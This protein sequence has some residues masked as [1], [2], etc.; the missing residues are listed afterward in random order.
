MST[1]ATF[2]IAAAHGITERVAKTWFPQ[3]PRDPRVMVPI[4]VEALVIRQPGGAWAET[5][6]KAP[7]QNGNGAVKH[8]TLLPDA[9]SELSA[10]DVKSRRAPGAYLHWALPDALTRGSQSDDK[11]NTEFPALPDRYGAV[12]RQSLPKT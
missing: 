10:D 8:K 3:L 5:Q 7:P 11:S 4:E 9:F 12:Y 6:M 2:T 1:P